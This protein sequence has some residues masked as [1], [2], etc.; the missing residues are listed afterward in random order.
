[1]ADHVMVVFTNPVPGREDEYN[2]WYNNV[3][4]GEVLRTPGM[5]CARRYRLVD[6][7]GSRE[8]PQ[9]RYLAIYELE[10]DDVKS[11]LKQMLGLPMNMSDALDAK[12][13]FMRVGN[14]A[15]PA[16]KPDPPPRPSPG[17]PPLLTPPTGTAP[18]PLRRSTF[19]R[20]ALGARPRGPPAGGAGSGA[21]DRSERSE[22]GSWAVR[23]QD[24]PASA[25]PGE[26]KRRATRG[27]R[28]SLLVDAGSGT[29]TCRRSAGRTRR[30][31]SR[32]YP[33]TSAARG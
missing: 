19:G 6:G 11:T 13:S 24:P 29:R 27:C 21:H 12:N 22:R 4:L 25:P 9:H 28:R 15:P 10:S 16:S 23:R 1:M 8:E 2:E 26:P 33:S 3:H 17:S 7:V 5:T 32:R 18:G 30:R 31:S 20:I 14:P